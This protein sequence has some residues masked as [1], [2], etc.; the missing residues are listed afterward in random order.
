MWK[1]YVGDKLKQNC[2]VVFLKGE[3]YLA[4]LCE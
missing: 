4:H 3:S 1:I 2:S